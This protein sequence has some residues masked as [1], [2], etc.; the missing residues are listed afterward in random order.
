MNTAQA[1]RD[2]RHARY[3]MSEVYMWAQGRWDEDSCP[4]GTLKHSGMAG[5]SLEKLVAVLEDAS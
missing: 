4:F 5:T 1:I 2:T 3:L